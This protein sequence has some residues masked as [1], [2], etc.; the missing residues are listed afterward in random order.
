M[1]HNYLR[2]NFERTSNALIRFIPAAV[3]MV[4]AS[5]DICDCNRNF[6]RADL[7]NISLN[8]FKFFL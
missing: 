5:L 6:I 4:D 7:E 8:I 1:C 2:K 3:V